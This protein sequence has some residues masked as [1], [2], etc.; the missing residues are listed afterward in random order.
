MSEGGSLSQ[1]EIDALLTAGPD[2]E[3]SAEEPAAPAEEPAAPAA[4]PAEESVAPAAGGTP[5]L[6]ESERDAIGEVGNICMSS[7][8]TTLS[9]LLSRP[10]QI[11][12]PLVEV[13]NE[14]EV[15]AQFNAPAVIV[16][17]DYT[18]G[19]DGRNVFLLSIPDASV[20]ADLMMGGEGTPSGE[21]SELHTSATAEA[22]NQMMGSASTAMAEMVGRRIDISA[23]Q[24]QVLDLA[25][26]AALEEL[27]I[28]DAMVRTS[29]QLHVGE[30]LDT[31]LM[32]LMPIDFA[33]A[34]VDGLLNPAAAPGPAAPGPEAPGA[35]GAEDDRHLH[36]LPA[37]PVA[38]PVT[39]PSLD[40]MPARPGG[41]DISLLLDVPLQVTVELGRTQLRIRNVLELVPG[42]IIELDKLAGE[43]VDV[44]VNGKPIARGEVVVIDEEFG[45]RITDVA[46]HAKRLRGLAADEA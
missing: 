35:G 21:L 33:R 4:A 19:L 41:S 27:G 1:E 13:V 23:P 24:V 16:S 2:A 32:Q 29:F 6:D 25:T 46:S 45:V 34:L 43:P 30:L 28:T 18:E 37:P 42:S 15:R 38:Q 8:A 10:V 39:F 12:T 22:M 14:E 40:D 20:V 5:G 36:A 26:D 7:A 44:L 3:P 11:T 31:T 17:I 9:L